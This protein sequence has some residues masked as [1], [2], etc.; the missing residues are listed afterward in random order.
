[1]CEVGSIQYNLECG[2]KFAIQE[3]LTLSK[4]KRVDAASVAYNVRSLSLI[5]ATPWLWLV[6][7]RS[8]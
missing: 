3:Y 5:V 7:C 8:P 6:S 4:L 1:M 2:E